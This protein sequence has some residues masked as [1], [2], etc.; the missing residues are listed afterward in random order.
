MTRKRLQP[1]TVSQLTAHG[2][3]IAAP[4]LSSRVV[5]RPGWRRA[6]WDAQSLAENSYPLRRP[7]ILA[8]PREKRESPERR[9]ACSLPGVEV[10]PRANAAMREFG[11]A[12]PR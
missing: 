12:A 5:R 3:M 9:G 4:P 1:A 10:R 2:T 11:R 7:R 6:L 8:G